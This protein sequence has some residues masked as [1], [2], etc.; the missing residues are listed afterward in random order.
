[1][2][3]F[4]GRGSPAVLFVAVLATAVFVGSALAAFVQIGGEL[5]S[6]AVSL[7]LPTPT[8]RP[9]ALRSV[10]YDDAGRPIA[11]LSG[12]QDRTYVKLDAVAPVLRHA[13]L[14]AEDRNF[15][16][17]GGVDWRSVT[18][19]LSTNLSAGNVV[20]GGST[21]A[22]QLVK[23][24]M[25]TRPA[26][27][28]QRKIKEAVLAIA[29]EHRYTKDQIFEQYLNTVYFGNGAYGVG[30]AAE[31]YFGR[32]AGTVDLAQAALLAA[33]IANPGSRDPITHTVAAARWRANVL[34]AM[35]KDRWATAAAVT[36]ARAEPLP[37]ALAKSNTDAF[38]DAFVE[39]VTRELLNDPRLA[40]TPAQRYRLV[41][42][43]GLRVFTTEDS[44]MERIAAFAAASL[45]TKAYTASMVVID[46]ATG[47]VR[48]VYPGANFHAN[49][50][51]LATQGAR[52]TGSAFKAITLAA[53]LEAGF[54]PND[55]VNA[56]GHCTL[57]YDPRVP[58]WNLENYE[59]ESLGTVT[60]TEALAK[61]SNCAFARVAI[62][63]GP[64]HIVDMA[65]RLGIARP[66]EAVPSI[67]LGTEEVTPLDM[68]GAL[69]V[70]ASDGVRRT[71]HFIDRV[72][73]A[74]GNVLF[75]NSTVGTRVLSPQI[76]RTETEMLE[77]VIRDGTARGTLG[78][79]PRPAAGKTGTNDRSRDVWFIGYTPQL[80]AAVW[81]GNPSAQIPVV[82]NGTYQVGGEYPARIWGEFMS[83]ALLG[84]PALDF[85]PPNAA[86]WP[87][88]R[89]ISE[90]GRAVIAPPTPPTPTPKKKAAT[91]PAPSATP[92]QPRRIH[93]GGQHP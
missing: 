21:I 65:H 3:S 35:Q 25:F 64:Q 86:L 23:N 91:P 1:M 5:V 89:M 84:Q 58:P 78:Q 41:Y 18:R 34:D 37:Q 44:R 70:I 16:T 82:I 19:A 62:A 14:A 52:Q 54:S 81:V 48:A 49:G 90:T 24:T 76:A 77:H 31:R 12:P 93:H 60:L 32:T 71:P 33:L 80:T 51:D 20:E 53:A 92:P 66:L 36:V 57:V 4:G 43:G 83:A 38:S 45:P 46:N 68:A 87:P 27:D 69:S 8:L 2:K 39:E 50:F 73:A 30:A 29:L 85:T 26:R 9:L 15:Y 40:S 63:L 59:G 6:H 10:V 11:T 7:Q 56:N 88:A 67:T 42:S 17:H 61:S 22:Q 55:L 74:N 75:Q 13:V 28:L 79:F 72:E 47:A